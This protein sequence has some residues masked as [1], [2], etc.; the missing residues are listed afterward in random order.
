MN[1]ETLK[2]K[3][4]ILDLA[5]A[6]ARKRQSPRTGLLH[7]FPQDETA[8]DVIPLYENFTFA[9]VLMR[10]KTAES[11]LE[12]KEILE[13]LLHFQTPEGNFPL[14]LHDF[15]KAWEF[16]LPLKIAPILIFLL[17]E[18]SPVLGTALKEKISQALQKGIQHI[19]KLRS[20]KPLS[21]IWELRY[22]ACIQGPSTPFQPSG[23]S[24]WFEWW[25]SQQ[26]NGCTSFPDSIPYFRKLQFFAEN[27]ASQEKREPR[28]SPIEWI[29]GERDGFTARLLRDHPNQLYAAIPPS[30]DSIQWPDF[31]ETDCKQ[32]ENDQGLQIVWGEKSLHT[33]VLP[34]GRTAVL[35]EVSDPGRGDLIEV[36]AFCDLEADIT[37]GGKKGTIF[38]LGDW[39]EIEKEGW[40]IGLRFQLLQGDGEFC[41]HIS[42][43]NRPSQIACKGPLL[44]EVY[45]WRI[46]LITLRKRS[47]CVIQTEVVCARSALRDSEA[48]S[49]ES[50]IAC[51]PLST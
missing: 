5:L 32:F 29:L 45:D 38:H 21:P 12:G 9:L 4:R 36:E 35:D 23:S 18:F 13:R 24:E 30:N 50:P 10:Q 47:P 11:V 31:D 16:H 41:G 15:P 25:I 46:S 48:L 17:R 34:K 40:R 44:Y 42:K 51:S 43:G 37:I 28:P 27:R 7:Y 8:S 14:F 1:I 2:K 26:L 19:E 39:V 49:T 33:F 6:A 20:E 3:E 22:Q